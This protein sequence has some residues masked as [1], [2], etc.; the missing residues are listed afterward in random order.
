MKLIPMM[1]ARPPSSV[2]TR[3]GTRPLPMASCRV[4]TT[5]LLKP[6]LRWLRESRTRR[7]QARL[8]NHAAVDQIDHG[9]EVVVGEPE[10]AL[11]QHRTDDL[12]L[13]DLLTTRVEPDSETVADPEQNPSR[14]APV[15]RPLDRAFVAL[16]PTPDRQQIQHGRVVDR[17]VSEIETLLIVAAWAASTP[18]PRSSTPA[19]GVAK[20]SASARTAPRSRRVGPDHDSICLSDERPG[21]SPCT[22]A[23]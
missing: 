14:G 7:A 10:V 22:A 19:K 21:E 2:T 12:V 1:P 13:R 5:T 8:G 18:K 16:S 15:R 17:A 23:P 20:I 6:A 3:R 11:K 9:D 4:V